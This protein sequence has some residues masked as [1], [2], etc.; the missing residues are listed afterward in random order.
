MKPKLNTNC[1]S[2]FC[3]ALECHNIKDVTLKTIPW[4][5][6]LLEHEKTRTL[7]HIQWGLQ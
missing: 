3:D 7:V 5:Q 4:G 6:T 2:H 1:P